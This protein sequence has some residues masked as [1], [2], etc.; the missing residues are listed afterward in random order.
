MARV[1]VESS[2]VTSVGF[3]AALSALDIEFAGGAVYRYFA[4]PAAVHAALM[5]ASSKGVFFNRHV[6]AKYP[7]ARV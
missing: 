2:S 7:F 1:A 6:R 3:N 5:A 4:V